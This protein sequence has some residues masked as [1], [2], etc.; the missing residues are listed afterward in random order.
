ML[1]PNFTSKKRHYIHAKVSDVNI[2]NAENPYTE[3][4]ILATAE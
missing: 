2:Q 4:E 3:M 1:I